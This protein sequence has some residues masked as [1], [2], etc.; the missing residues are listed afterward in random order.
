MF[1]KSGWYRCK[2]V[3]EKYEG[4][5]FQYLLP[6]MPHAKMKEIGF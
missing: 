4:S 2:P 1:K 3:K 5:N 6:K